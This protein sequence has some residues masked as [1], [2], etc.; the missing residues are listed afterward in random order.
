M[1]VKSGRLEG[2]GGPQ[3]VAEAP[4]GPSD[5]SGIDRRSELV[6]LVRADSKKFTASQ[7]YREV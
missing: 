1:R 4:R 3:R 6:S 7:M 2:P 5:A